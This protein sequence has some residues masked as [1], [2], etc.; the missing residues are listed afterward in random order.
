MCT[1]ESCNVLLM[2]TVEPGTVFLIIIIIIIM[3]IS[4]IKNIEP[5]FSLL[6][7]LFRFALKEV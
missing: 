3:L 5:V 4:I 1:D 7:E 2:S 6:C